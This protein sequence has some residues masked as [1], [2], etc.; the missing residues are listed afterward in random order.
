MKKHKVLLIF[1]FALAA[2][3]LSGCYSLSDST[4]KRL[5][6]YPGCETY[7]LKNHFTTLEMASNDVNILVN[8]C[9]D[10]KQEKSI[11]MKYPTCAIEFNESH[12]AGVACSINIK[13][14]K[15]EEK[16]KVRQEE[17]EKKEK[18]RRE[19]LASPAGKKRLEKYQDR[20]KNLM[21]I[22]NKLALDVSRKYNVGTYNDTLGANFISE[23]EGICFI[24]Y[25]GTTMSGYD[26]ITIIEIRFDF[27][28]GNYEIRRN[29]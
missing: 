19:Y 12:E 9:I 20:Q 24:R 4:E 11:L 5:R 3:S 17:L 22:C 1:P 26:K 29:N 18:A 14:E 7:Y 28:S 21:P 13:R 23:D 25:I 16:E 15:E 10:S 27:E 2:F 6:N 8:K